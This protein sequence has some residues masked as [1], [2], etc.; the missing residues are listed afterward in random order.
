MQLP[1]PEDLKIRRNEIGFTLRD[2]AKRAGLI[3][4]IIACIESGDVDL[5]LFTVR[6]ILDAFE[7]AEKVLLTLIRD[8]IHFPVIHISPADSIEE[9]VNLMV[10]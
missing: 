3:Q 8:L 6:K 5:R 2:L 4:P 9:A 1:T 10:Y 7:K